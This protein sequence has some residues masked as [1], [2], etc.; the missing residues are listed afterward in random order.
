MINEFNKANLQQVRADI[1]A[2]LKA[3]EEKHGLTLSIGSISYSGNTFSSKMT[4]IT[5][6]AMPAS[7]STIPG[8]SKWHAD[9]LKHCMFYGMSKSDL[10]KTIKIGARS[11]IISGMRPRADK[12]MLLKEVGSS[13]D[14]FMIMDV[15]SVVQALKV[16]A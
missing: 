11:Y 7:S 5:K 3:V 1:A 6:S 8:N 9:F 10:G 15:E 14:K 12:Q 13:N 4:A 16:A 2:A